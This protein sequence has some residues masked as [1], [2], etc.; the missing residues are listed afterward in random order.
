MKYRTRVATA[1]QAD[2][3]GL[4]NWRDH[5]CKLRL[6]MAVESIRDAKER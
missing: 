3:A 4:I 2:A 5:A 6:A 1:N